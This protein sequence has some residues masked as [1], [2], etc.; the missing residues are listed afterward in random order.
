[1]EIHNVMQRTLQMIQFTHDNQICD[2]DVF[3]LKHIV[4]FWK[5]VSICVTLYAFKLTFN[6][7]FMTFDHV[8][9]TLRLILLLSSEINQ[10]VVLGDLT[11]DI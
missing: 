4:L 5:R 3:V 10:V 11:I 2:A 6:K 1:M 7:S 8:W 9:D